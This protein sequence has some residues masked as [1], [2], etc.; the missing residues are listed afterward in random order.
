MGHVQKRFASSAAKIAASVSTAH[1][2]QFPPKQALYVRGTSLPKSAFVPENWAAVQPPPPSALSAFAHRIGLASILSTT[3]IV[4]QACTHP[5][6]LPLYRQHF[7]NEQEPLTNA[8]LS[9]LGNSLMGLFAA[10]YLHA[11]FPYL[12]TRVLKAAVTAHVGPLTC[13]SVAQEMG[14]APLARWQRTV[15]FLSKLFLMYRLIPCSRIKRSCDL[16]CYILMRL[17]LFPVP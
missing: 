4:Q 2:P 11:K 15:S 16:Q 10:E 13:S 7:P 8:Q 6:Y 3:D 1:I 5:S 12:P 14:A 17:P 9:P